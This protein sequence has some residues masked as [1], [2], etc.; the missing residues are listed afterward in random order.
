MSDKYEPTTVKKSIQVPFPG[1][2]LELRN[3]FIFPAR[4]STTKQPTGEMAHAKAGMYLHIAGG[5]TV[6]LTGIDL[7]AAADAQDKLFKKPLAKE[8]LAEI[9]ATR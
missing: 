5:R 2:S 3:N 4:D 6:D 8:L 1:A 7:R 9:E